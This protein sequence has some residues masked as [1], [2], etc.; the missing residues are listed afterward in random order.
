MN[1]YLVGGAVRDK[2]MGISS[3]DRDYV[4]VG[5]TPEEM[6][7]LGFKPIGKDF[8]VF[9]HPKTNEEY[10]LAR[11]EKKVGKGYHGFKF[12]TSPA[13]T[14]EEDLKRRDITINA[15]AEDEDGK[16]YDPFNGVN[17]IKNKIIKHVSNAF[18]EDPLRVFRV[19][20]FYARFKDFE[21]HQDTEK[22]I[23][24]IVSSGEIKSL[25]VERIYSEILKGLEEKHSDKMFLSFET[26]G[27]LKEIFPEFNYSSIPFHALLK[28]LRNTSN[29]IKAESKFLMILVLPSLLD[30]EIESNNEYYLDFFRLSRNA[31]NLF[32]SI[33]SEAINLEN[34]LSLSLENK[35]DCLY[36]LDFFRRPDI[37]MEILDMLIFLILARSKP[38]PSSHSIEREE[39]LAYKK[40]VIK[41]IELVKNLILSFKKE[42]S[43]IR[44]TTDP[45]KS[46]EKIKEL[47]YQERLAILKKLVSN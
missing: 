38:I 2:L 37:T 22:L 39:N 20:R 34:F 36:R 41:K 10:A 19:A 7:K 33:K 21:I 8:P 29:S 24:K 46:V 11:T 31:K 40:N 16:I 3:K 1:I 23:K 5:S 30:I 4:V 14:L 27:V 47:I 32:K 45:L 28:A 42:L 6:I 43:L 26:S 18:C 17:D 9:L 44:S 25:S 13:V 15:I 12:F 35:L